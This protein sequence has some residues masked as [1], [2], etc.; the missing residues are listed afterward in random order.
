MKKRKAIFL[1]NLTDEERAILSKIVDSYN[2]SHNPVVNSEGFSGFRYEDIER[3][4][5][6]NLHTDKQTVNFAIELMVESSLLQKTKSGR[7]YLNRRY[8]G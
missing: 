4:V 2:P 3:R 5:L 1:V 6:S 7:Y 8:T